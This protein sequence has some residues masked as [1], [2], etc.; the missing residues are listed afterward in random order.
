MRGRYVIGARGGWD[1]M[2]CRLRWR[3]RGAGLQ[4]QAGYEKYWHQ[5][6]NAKRVKEGVNRMSMSF[7][8]S[9][10]PD[11]VSGRSRRPYKTYNNSYSSRLWWICGNSGIQDLLFPRLQ[12][13]C[14]CPRCG[15]R[16]AD[17]EVALGFETMSMILRL[18]L[19][20]SAQA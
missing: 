9:D 20:F 1:T 13:R 14:H 3:L 2:V 11:R 8:R 18:W 17:A 5:R 10:R 15:T 12:V 6:I 4:G 16:L 19:R 7:E